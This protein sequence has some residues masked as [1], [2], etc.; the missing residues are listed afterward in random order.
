ML[1]GAGRQCVVGDDHV[2]DR[3]IAIKIEMDA[4]R[5]CAP[6]SPLP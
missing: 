3:A 4:A 2:H 1:V 5:R 6:S